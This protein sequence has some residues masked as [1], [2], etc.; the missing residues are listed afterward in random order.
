LSFICEEI[1]VFYIFH[2]GRKYRT[3]ALRRLT[4]NYLPSE[5]QI[6]SMLWI[7]LHR[8]NS[9]KET[10]TSLDVKISCRDQCAAYGSN[11][12]TS[13]KFLT[14]KLNFQIKSSDLPP[15]SDTSLRPWRSVQSPY[16]TEPCSCEGI[17][18]R[19]PTA[20]MLRSYL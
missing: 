15:T 10:G 1:I 8:Y 5:I 16:N 19:K 14:L 6:S 13:G 12:Y 2:H 3:R 9:V 17:W 4:S 18:K 7:K 11:Y 20:I